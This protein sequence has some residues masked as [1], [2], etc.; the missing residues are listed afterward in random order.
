MVFCRPHTP[1]LRCSYSYG[2]L[3]CLPDELIETIISMY[4]PTELVAFGWNQ[5]NRGFAEIIDKKLRRCTTFCV[6]EDTMW[7]FFK[8]ALHGVQ[9]LFE[10][11]SYYETA[12]MLS[13]LEKITVQIGDE[14]GPLTLSQNFDNLKIAKTM[15]H[16]LSEV[17]VDVKVSDK[18]DVT[19]CGL[20]EL[21]RYLMEVTSSKTIWN[22]T[23]EDCTVQG[24]G[25]FGPTDLNR[26]RNKAFIC[27]VRTVLDLGVSINRLT[28]LDKRKTSPYMLVMS[29]S[30]RRTI[31]MYPEFKRCRELFVCYDIGL[32]APSFAHENDRFDSLQVIEVDESH[33]LYKADLLEYLKNA[34][35]LTEMRVVVPASWSR[36]V[37]SCTRGCFSNPDFACFRVDGW[38]GIHVKLPKTKFELVGSDNEG[39]AVEDRNL[40]QFIEYSNDI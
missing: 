36:R 11:E 22:L 15:C 26:C 33:V 23:L 38:C 14:W 6:C 28:L 32:V 30:K 4:S 31:Y 12:S 16:S 29:G 24:Q 39:K 25:W 3:P 19:C 21:V 5:V 7:Q 40:N 27:Y 10:S 9:F 37:S 35:N 2:N 8:P 13:S 17:N 18:E 34:C 1:I 20:R